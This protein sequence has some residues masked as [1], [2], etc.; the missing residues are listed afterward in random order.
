MT[1]PNDSDDSERAPDTE[2]GPD[3]ERAPDGDAGMNKETRMNTVAIDVMAVRAIA[4]AARLGREEEQEAEP[5]ARAREREERAGASEAT[6]SAGGDAREERAG[7]SEATTSAGGDARTGEAGR[8]AKPPQPIRAEKTLEVVY[9]HRPRRADGSRA[10]LVLASA[11]LAVLLVVAWRLFTSPS[12]AAGDGAPASDATSAKVAE[13]KAPAAAIPAAAATDDAPMQIEGSVSS[14]TSAPERST[15][16]TVPV[17]G[18]LAAPEPTS[19]DTKSAPS[20]TTGTGAGVNAAGP[21]ATGAAA[22]GTSATK[23][24]RP[25]HLLPETGTTAPP[26]KPSSPGAT[27]I[28]Y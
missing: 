9:A 19:V 7:A 21:G 16:S 27:I 6:T 13:M 26:P 11:S 2:R 18:A 17:P 3:A 15:I 12:P 28:P 10:T 24:F 20:A 1:T 22:G 8:D 25:P 14:T 23:T 5:P 4:K